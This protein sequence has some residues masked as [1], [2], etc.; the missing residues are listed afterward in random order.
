MQ[1]AFRLRKQTQQGGQKGVAQQ[2]TKKL[3]H[4]AEIGNSH[5]GSSN[6]KDEVQT[7]MSDAG[8][9]LRS[10]RRVRF[11]GVGIV[12]LRQRATVG[13]QDVDR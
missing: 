1:I 2:R 12:E 4:Q 6:L 5:R 7:L 8:V 3:V 11:K 9:R 10:P 13:A